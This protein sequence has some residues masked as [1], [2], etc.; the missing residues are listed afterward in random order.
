M[1]HIGSI[2]VE[3]ANLEAARLAPPAVVH[4]H[5][6]AVGVELALGVVR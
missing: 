6:H 1:E 5:E 2:A 3:L 4:E